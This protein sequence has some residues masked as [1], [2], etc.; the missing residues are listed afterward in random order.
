MTKIA[1]NSALT[2]S[3]HR[4]KRFDISNGGA[5]FKNLLY[6]IF[7]N[8]AVRKRVRTFVPKFKAKNILIF[9]IVGFFVS[10]STTEN[11]NEK[12]FQLLVGLPQ[13][14]IGKCSLPRIGEESLL[15]FY[16]NFNFLSTMAKNEENASK[17]LGT[18]TSTFNGTKTVSLDLFGLR[19]NPYL[20][21][22]RK[23]F[24]EFL[25]ELTL[26]YAFAEVRLIDKIKAA[27]TL[28]PEARKELMSK[29]VKV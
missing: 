5:F 1:I 24:R 12:G 17:V 10:T 23:S 4:I 8:L 25:R 7:L 11:N 21:S 28:F 26:G 13:Y 16:T 2:N 19:S 20:F 15:L 6:N 27:D 29:T 22:I 14:K 3:C 9:V 18:N